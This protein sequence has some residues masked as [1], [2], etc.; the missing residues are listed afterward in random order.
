MHLDNIAS[1][2]STVLHENNK[3]QMSSRYIPAGKQTERGDKRGCERC[4]LERI[5]DNRHSLLSEFG[6]I[7]SRM[8]MQLH[9]TGGV[10]VPFF[11]TL[12]T[13]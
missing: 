10:T 12:F 5:S 8:E 13:P 4:R 2:T 1:C 7:T 11:F 6:S 3:R 9:S